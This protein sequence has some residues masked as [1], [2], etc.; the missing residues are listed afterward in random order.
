[1]CHRQDGFHS[2]FSL[3]Q[4]E[5]ITSPR[6]MLIASRDLFALQFL[7]WKMLWNHLLAFLSLVWSIPS[8][9]MYLE[10]SCKTCI[11]KMALNA[12][13]FLWVCMC[14]LPCMVSYTAWSYP[15]AIAGILIPVAA[16]SLWVV[17]DSTCTFIALCKCIYSSSQIT[18]TNKKPKLRNEQQ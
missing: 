15:E 11:S 8:S 14:T 4:L 13:V 7:W 9:Y 17:S 1:M 18:K 3:R 5:G 2:I 6:C 12:W 10:F 16:L